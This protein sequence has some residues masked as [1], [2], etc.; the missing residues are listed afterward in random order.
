MLL[1]GDF[2]YFRPATL[3]EAL[4]LLLA[5][6]PKARIMAGGTDLVLEMKR[7]EAAPE[8]L[9]D[10]TA[11]PELRVLE[12][13]DHA[14]RIGAACTFAAICISPHVRECAPALAGAAAQVGSPQI[15]AR[16]TIGGNVGTRSPAG[17]SLPPLVAHGAE[18]V[19][20]SGTGERTVRI[21]EMLSG[22]ERL[23]PDELIREFSIP[24]REGV[25]G[26][27]VKLGRRNALA[28]AR[29]SLALVA[30]PAA[31]GG[32]ARVAL[33]TLGIVPVRVPEAEE[34]IK[35]RGLDPTAWPELAEATSR[36]VER[37]IPGRPTAP[38]K[39]RAVKGIVYEALEKMSH[40]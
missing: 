12:C 26:V 35:T 4:E 21:E 17:D 33:G 14:L 10:V 30:H 8:V 37:S 23:G 19:V 39:M 7:G 22:A 13:D 31:A 34:L 5:H 9:V 32:D 16:G 29:L 25:K 36:A 11:V 20:V 15:R 3:Q 27:F 1:P 28:I 2:E 18:A 24:K 38:Y 6:G 40:G